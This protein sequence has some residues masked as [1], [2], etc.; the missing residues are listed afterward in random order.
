M[1]KALQRRKAADN[2]SIMLTPHAVSSEP[3]C[4]AKLRSAGR[5]SSAHLVCL[6]L[7]WLGLLSGCS[8]LDERQRGWIYRPTPGHVSQWRP[9]TEHDQAIWVP[10]LASTPNQG[11]VPSGPLR[12]MWVPQADP[13][14][15]AVLYFHGTLRHVFDNRDKI[16]AIHQ[17]GFSVLA[18]DYRG[19]GESPTLLPSEAS[20]MED[21]EASWHEF[22]RRVPSPHKRVI[23]GHSM[24]S[25]VAVEVALRRTFPEREFA[26]LVVEAPFTSMPDIAKDAHWLG[27]L[28]HGLTTQQFRSI[29]KI[30]RIAGPVWVLSGTA[31]RTVPHHH[32]QKLYQAA[33]APKRLSTFEGGSHSLLQAEFPQAY[34]QTWL[35]VLSVLTDR[36]NPGHAGVHTHTPKP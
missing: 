36:A 31:D 11:G 20:I 33:Q 23:F 26:A 35:E 28:M 24:G 14:A 16:A 25:G 3:H 22:I 4:P 1:A 27:W 34:R 15:P 5:S 32:A 8:W 10:A 30:H 21:A 13:K 18:V 19:Y 6:A 29:E 7:V 17:A 12:A 2:L 9:I